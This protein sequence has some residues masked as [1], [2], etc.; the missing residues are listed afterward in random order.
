M[1]E[2]EIGGSGHGDTEWQNDS[3]EFRGGCPRSC[4]LVRVGGRHGVGVLFGRVEHLLERLENSDAIGEHPL[5]VWTF[6][7]SAYGYNGRPAG[8]A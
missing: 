1:N 6:K 2:M 4:L 8:P 5:I 3:F 7:V